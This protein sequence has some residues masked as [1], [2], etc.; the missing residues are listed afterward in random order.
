MHVHLGQCGV[1]AELADKPSGVK[2]GPASQVAPVE[3]DHITLTEFGEM[4]SY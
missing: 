3:Q 1:S 4:K 2:G